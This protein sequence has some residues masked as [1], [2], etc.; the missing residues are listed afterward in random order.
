MSQGRRKHRLAFKVNLPLGK[1]TEA[2]LSAHYQVHQ[3]QIQ[4]CKRALT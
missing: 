3:S 4:A 2:Q 1:E